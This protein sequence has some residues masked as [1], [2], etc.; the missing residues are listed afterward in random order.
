MVVVVRCE[1]KPAPPRVVM[2]RVPWKVAVLGDFLMC[3]EEC[4]A[5]PRTRS[6]VE[7]QLVEDQG[8]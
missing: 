8:L 3:R 1:A 2:S 6:S 7:V 5:P 4:E